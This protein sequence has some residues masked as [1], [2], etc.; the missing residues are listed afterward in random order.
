[1]N[2]V[3]RIVRAAAAALLIVGFASSA[4][5]APPPPQQ[6]G[7][8]MARILLVDR[9]DILTRSAAG[10]SIMRQVQAM[11]VSAKA[12]L[13]ARGMGLQKEYQQIQQQAAILSASV[14]DGKLKAF[15]AKKIALETDMQRQQGLIQGGLLAA[16]NQL[17]GALKP[18]LQKIMQERGGN[19]LMERG[20][21]LEWMP[22]VDVTDVAIQRLNQALP[23]VVVKP[24][25]P[26]PQMMQQQQQ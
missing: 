6:G 10:Q 12:N 25:A 22:A 3:S 7:A 18:V 1:M 15:N 21:A 24:T 16:R 23:N 13:N 5:A 14:K 19:I 8:P 4:L 20:A 9:N 26:P 2:D 11:V 17:L